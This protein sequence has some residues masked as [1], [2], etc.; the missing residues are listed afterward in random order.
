MIGVPD[1]NWRI[2]HALSLALFGSDSATKVGATRRSR[3][4]VT[5]ENETRRKP[6]AGRD[7]Y[8]GS[9]VFWYFSGL[10]TSFGV[11]RNRG[12]RGSAVGSESRMG[13][14]ANGRWAVPE[15]RKLRPETHDCDRA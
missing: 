12:L 8:G 11:R 4:R 10:E 6:L 3:C 13:D 9:N 14:A 7:E 15:V 5:F 1:D 2:D